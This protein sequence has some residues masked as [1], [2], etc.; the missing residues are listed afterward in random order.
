MSSKIDTEEKA[1]IATV[2]QFTASLE[3]ISATIAD[4]QSERNFANRINLYS[5]DDYARLYIKRH[6]KGVLKYIDDHMNYATFLLNNKEPFIINS[7]HR[8][9]L[10]FDMVDKIH[11]DPLKYQF[12]P[13]GV[14]L[15][16]KVDDDV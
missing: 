2:A 11:A 7:D 6:E 15:L 10:C 12:T 4:L 1:L 3:T 9:E 14:F 13:L 5:F 16:T 8:S